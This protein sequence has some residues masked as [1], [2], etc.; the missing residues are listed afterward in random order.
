VIL[1]EMTKALAEMDLDV[2]FVFGRREQ[3]KVER[4]RL[5]APFPQAAKVKST[6]GGQARPL[7]ITKS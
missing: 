4:G 1:I 3:I 6:G 2:F 5:S 7:W